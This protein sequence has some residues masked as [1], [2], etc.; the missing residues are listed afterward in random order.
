MNA[1]VPIRA[2]DSVATG[3]FDA[4]IGNTPLIQL[5]VGLEGRKYRVFAKAEFHSLTGSTKDRMAASVIFRARE[6]G[7]LAPGQEIVEMTSGNAGIA[8]AAIGTSLGHRVTIF[9][10]DWMSA[11]RRGLLRSFGADLNLVSREEGGFR[12]ALARSEAYA[13]EFGAFL[14]RQFAN[15]DNVRAHRDG[16][17]SELLRQLAAM[18]LR[19]DAFVAGVGTGGTVMGVAECFA[20]AGLEASVHPV[21]PRESPTLSTGYKVGHHRIQG[22][23]DEFIPEIVQLDRLARPVAVSDSCAIRLAQRLG[24]ELGMGVGISSGAN[25]LAAIEV[26]RG[27]GDGA[28]VTTVFCDNSLRYLSTDL[29][30]DEPVRPGSIVTEIRFD[31]LSM[32]RAC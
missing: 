7:E 4:L 9:M 11:E 25:L 23:S 32:F 27:L 12:G 26:A 17:G 31:G 10:P 5:D 28:V 15:V 2:P 8:L 29:A 20:A 24:R 13:S 30:V 14:T 16:T 1:I 18:G 3:V 22:I 19:P 6:R 21:E